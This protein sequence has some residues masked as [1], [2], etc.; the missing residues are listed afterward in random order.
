MSE[1]VN[2]AVAV[3]GIGAVLPDA[4]NASTF[5]TNVR[6]GRYSISDVPEGRWDPSLYFDADAKAPD[7]TYSK[8]GGW[9]TQWDWDPLKWRLPIPPKVSDSMDRTHIWSIVAAREALLDY[10][11]PD[12]E[13]DGDRTAVVLGNAM[14]GDRH[15]QTAMRIYLPEYVRELRG[16]PSFSAL[17]PAVQAAVLEEFKGRLGDVL[18]EITEDTM[19][20]ELANITAGRIANLFNFH[21]PNFVTDAACASALAGMDAAIEGLEQGN[22][23]TVLTGGV[24]A[25]MSASTFVKFCKIGA[26]S[27]T[28]TRPYG[29]GADGFVMGEGAAVFLLKRLEDAEKSGDHIYAVV[30]G[31]AGSSDGRGKGITA[32]NPVGQKFAVKRAW[33]NAGTKP[34]AASLMEGHGTSTRVGDVV[35]VE[36]LSEVFSSL[37]MSRGSLPL[38][39]VKSNIGHL[40]A[41]AGAAGMLKAVMALNDKVLPPSLNAEAT[42]PNIDFKDSPLF[43]NT[44]LQEWKA[45]PGQVRQAGVSAFGFGGT[46]FHVVLEEYI[47]GRIRTS[48]NKVTYSLVGPDT[49]GRSDADLKPPIRGALVVGGT[50]DEDVVARLRVTAEAANAGTVPAIDV[51]MEEDLRSDVRVAIDYADATDLASKADRAIAAL[52]GKNDAAWQ[53]LA[54]Q[55][56]FH[57]TGTAGQ[58]A[59]LYTG[60]GSQYVN[61]LDTLRHT[62]PIVANTFAEADAVMTPILS[63]PLTDYIFIDSDDPEA[64]TASEFDLMQTE[65]TQ[66]AV[67][68]VDIALTRLMAAY[69]VEPNMVMGHSLG[70]YGALVAAGSLPFDEALMAVAGR[71]REMASVVVEDRGLMAAV[72]APLE[73]IEAVVESVDGYV[74]IANVNSHHQAVIGGATPA[75]ETAMEQL[76]EAGHQVIQL[77]VSHAF[78]TEIVAPASG[79]LKAVL[80]RLDLRSPSIPVIANITGDFYPRGPQVETEM[81]EIL[82]KQIASP[83]QFVK[84]LERLYRA[85]ARV[86]VEMGPKK[87][88]HGLTEDVLGDRG[89]VRSLFTNHPK[90]GDAVSFNQAL[91]GLYA[92]GIGTGRAAE[93]SAV[94]HQPTESATDN[95]RE[96][97]AVSHRPS[98]PEVAGSPDTYGQL[99]HLLADFLDSAYEV[100]QG[101]PAPALP[102]SPAP[103]NGPIAPVVV[104]GAGIGLPGMARVFDESALSRLL[105]GEQFI[106]AIPIKNR[107]DIVDH[108]ITR[109]VKSKEGGGRFET[110]DS[111]SDVIKLAGRGGTVDLAEEFGFPE[112]RIVALERTSELAIGAGIDALTDAGIPLVM[113]YKTATTGAMIQERWMLP[114]AMRDT[115]AVIFASA[116]PGAS[117]FIDEATRFAEDK[118]KHERLSE[119]RELRSRVQDPVLGEDLD[120]RIRELGAELS[121]DGYA[122]DRRYLYRAL[123]FAH[124]QF[125]EYIGARGPNTQV[126]AACAS[127]T[128]AVAIAED[129]INARRCDRVIIISAD[130][131]TSDT[132]LGWIGSGFLAVGAAATDEVVE[133]AAVPFDRRRHGMILG[134]GAAALVV[135]SVASA[136][137][138]GIQPLAEVLAAETANSAFHGSRLD[139]AHIKQVM[140]KLVATAESRWGISRNE[141][142]P[143]MMFV[144]HETYTPARGGSAQAE[145]DALRFV[146]ADTADSIVITNTKGYTGHAMA[147]GVEDVLAIKAM[148]T[149]VVPRV[150]NFKEVDPDLGNLNL[151]QGGTYPVRYGLRLG[152]GFGSQVSMTLYRAIPSPLGRHPDIDQLGFEY[153]VVDADRWT[154][155]LREVTGYD[156]PE[157]EVVKRTLRVADHGSPQ[158]QPAQPA[159]VEPPLRWTDPSYQPSAESAGDGYQAPEPVGT[160]VSSEVAAGSDPVAVKVLEIVAAE[161][162]YP[163]DMLALDLDLEADL[164]IDT[165]KQAEMFAAIREEW[166]IERDDSVALR[167]YPTLEHVIGFVYD[168]TDIDRP[169]AESAGDGYQ[170]PE[171]VGT[172]VSSEVAAGSD[173]VAVKVLEIVAAETGYPADML[174]LDLDLEADLG[175]DTVKQAEMFAAI[176]EEWGIERDDS[177]ALRDYPTLEHVIGFVY[178]GTDID[179]PS[180]ESAGDGYQAPEPVG[181]VVSSE[182]AAGSDPVAVKVLEIVAAETGYPADMLALDLDLEADLGIDTVKQAE[183]F[184]AIREEWGIERDDSVALRD[185][186]TLEHVIGFV[187]DGTDIDRPSAESAGDGYQ[188]PEPVGT[189]V[190]SEVAAGSDPVAV[191]VLEIVAAETGYPADMLALD[192]DLEADLG[193]DTVK[194]AEM[195]AAIREEWGI[196]RD[197]SVALRDYPTLEHVIGFVY[198]GTD[199]DRPSAESAGDGYQAPEPPLTPV[200]DE[201]ADVSIPR[202]IPVPVLRPDL[203]WCSSTGVTIGES[204]RV[205]VFADEGGVGASLI[206]RLEKRGVDILA[207]DRS[208]D[209][210]SLAAAL[211]AWGTADVTG[212]YWLPGLDA[213][214]PI[215]DLD[216]DAW[217]EALRV[218]VKLL[219]ATMRHLYDAVGGPGSF[220]VSATRLGGQHGYG[221]V[222]PTAPMGGAVTGFTKTYKREKPE[223]LVKAIDFPASRKTAALAEML[224]EETLLDPGA[225]E[226]GRTEDGRRWSVGLAAIDLPV[227]PSGLVLTSESVFVVTGAAGSIVSAITADLAGASGGTFHLLDL[228]PEPDASDPN[229]DLFRTNRDELQRVIFASLAETGKRA[230]PAMVEREIAAIERSSAALEAIEAIE[231]GGGTALYHSVNLLDGEAM[232]D[233]MTRIAEAHDR[234]DV[235]LHAGGLEISRLLPDKQPNEFDLVFDVKA[236]GWFSL[237]KGLESIDLGAVVSFSSI[238]GRFGNG[239]QADYS[240]ANDL[241][242]KSSLAFAS[243]RPGTTAIAIDW[244]AWGDIGMATRGSI[245]TVMKAAGIDMLPASI[246]TPLVRQEIVGATGSREV[247]VAGRLGMLMEEFDATGGIHAESMDVSTDSVMV[248]EVAA[249]GLHTGLTVSTTLDPKEQGFLFDH[250]IDGTPVLPGVMG[251]EAFAEIANLPFE[252][253]VVQAIEDVDFV[254]PFKFYRN[255]PRTLT[256]SAVFA[257]DG[258]DVIARCRLIGVRELATSDEPQVTTHFTGTV[259]L[260]SERL[261]VEAVVAPDAASGEVRSD[262]VYRVYFHGPTYQVLAS[263]WTDGDLVGGTLAA[264]IPPNHVPEHK[265]TLT[266]PRLVELCFQTA[267]MWQIGTTGMMALP[268]HI[269]RVIIGVERPSDRRAGVTAIVRPVDGSFDAVVVD[270]SGKALVAI[271]G[272]RTIQLPGA[273]SDDE[274][275]PLREAMTPDA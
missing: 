273:L 187:Y 153:R 208:L 41:A 73:E 16:A 121:A 185:Y 158:R 164:G 171:P 48:D 118:A 248:G 57:G 91:C 82:G 76:V 137:E 101:R 104:T 102:Q 65:I 190:S 90:Q 12:K 232:S 110:I 44:E 165:V 206:D 130:D 161:T 134:M 229:I 251:I 193:I 18:P 122:F 262:D 168:G 34:D 54:N 241:L 89:D 100:Y 23:D 86:F 27:A 128:Q 177:V 39:S 169:S 25:N 186:P 259:R 8:I 268:M 49:G 96:P 272:Y 194:Q 67:L 112:D 179:R 59:F 228:V 4:P 88:L 150:P 235:V 237:L 47:P 66:P 58:V 250:Q 117:A 87:A 231:A 10:G 184:A 70:E 72:F 135:E 98:A 28:G 143:E 109:L 176:R 69:G 6:N 183:M 166:G 3:V 195:F 225:V 236:D 218:R 220:L 270:G 83:V 203:G 163:A 22:Y 107:Q 174:A 11:Y 182:V 217:R 46:N 15:Y 239:G 202:R 223:A 113:R 180:A 204:S 103:R 224:V 269:D 249:F 252:D 21:G 247:L 141:I 63:K 196:E 198:D 78:H 271:E 162:G 111:Q 20:G 149:G 144:S 227:E 71:G 120:R 94:S 246:G 123:S 145:I 116:F 133:E 114:E 256:V 38:G 36:S 45:S 33:E 148:E 155:W 170:A 132:M 230:T 255:E 221:S 53:L 263:A 40:K 172:V 210:E 81:I 238:A 105:H 64:V 52:E 119:L 125:A 274:V 234:V 211:D 99:G 43:V 181:T 142:A 264:D 222:A 167:D 26:L 2:R 37:G 157:I 17:D 173:P 159:T 267:G 79:P 68:A 5:W 197:D 240:A 42:N 55:G 77:P 257:S 189:V 24:D 253:L 138:R 200:S 233:V 258:D 74:V 126:N 97:P 140:E 30:R 214:K 188:A 192:L 154:S 95:R 32:P 191:K 207:L 243:T 85:G 51:P 245:P 29:A 106:D 216:L 124:A 108:H 160:V 1:R 244:T 115:T 62:E 136:S 242:C 139:P 93:P 213:D 175:I 178:D 7:K 131:V 205:V 50:S 261:P 80:A 265:L 9:A 61:M 226:I 75:V 219:Y 35:E 129:W 14:G 56:V 199:I 151:S 260:S 31:L 146:F 147:T 201:A 92:A 254:A 156:S 215:N 19:P 13:L 212:V 275:A 127:T 60:Q 152:A 84:G 266:G 209:A